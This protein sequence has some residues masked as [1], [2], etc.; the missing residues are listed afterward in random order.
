MNTSAGSGVRLSVNALLRDA[1]AVN[2]TELRAPRIA[3]EACRRSCS[4]A[5]SV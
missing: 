1:N 3:A 4:I 2:I 5:C